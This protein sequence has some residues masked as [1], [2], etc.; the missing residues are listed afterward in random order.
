MVAK[1]R[2]VHA[3]LFTRV[4]HRDTLRHVHLLTVHRHGHRVRRRR[5]LG[6]HRPRPDRLI[7]IDTVASSSV[8]R[9]LAPRSRA[10]RTRLAF[11]SSPSAARPSARRSPRPSRA[12]TPGSDR[13][14]PIAPTPPRALVHRLTRRDATPR[15]PHHVS[16]ALTRSN[17]RRARAHVPLPDR[18]PDPASS[19]L[20]RLPCVPR[21]LRTPRATRRARIA[22]ERRAT[23]LRDAFRARRGLERR[24]R[25]CAATGAREELNLPR[26]VES[27]PVERGSA[28]RGAATRATR[29]RERAR[30]GWTTGIFSRAIRGRDGGAREEGDARRRRAR[31]R[32]RPFSR[33]RYI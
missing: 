20:D 31:A 32:R 2:H 22:A 30:G 23:S 10:R 26:A 25:A 3:R 8:A 4:Q 15:I 28:P 14:A 18:A 33:E 1:S 21:S 6:A 19:R 11:A 27:R 29:G 5:R 17:A 24:A 12:V 16:H 13:R 9:P 7:R